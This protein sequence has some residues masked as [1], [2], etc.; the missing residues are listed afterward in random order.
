MTAT[1]ARISPFVTAGRIA[2]GP[3]HV[4][5]LT[6]ST[7]WAWANKRHIAKRFNSS[8]S[9]LP[10]GYGVATIPDTVPAFLAN[11]MYSVS[12]DPSVLRKSE[13]SDSEF[14]SI[15]LRAPT[16]QGYTSAFTNLQAST[17]ANDYITYTAL[18]S[19]D[20][21]KCQQ[22]CDS[23]TGCG[24]FNIYFERQPTVDPNCSANPPSTVAIKCARWGSTASM[25]PSLAT[26]NG[27][28]RGPPDANGAQF[29]VVISGSNGKSV[30]EFIYAL[31][32]DSI[33]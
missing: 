20:P 8:C 26:N 28:F 5:G 23:D 6:K 29:H 21:I 15:A 9:H 12:C 14:Q 32:V 1:A 27:Q 11:P 16:P 10:A 22:L 13:L 17:Q 18:Q 3:F 25:N 2:A 7:A 30:G 4:P 33:D 19:Y 24:G 31:D